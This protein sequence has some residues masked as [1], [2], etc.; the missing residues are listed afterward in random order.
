MNPNPTYYKRSKLSGDRTAFMFDSLDAYNRFIDETDRVAQGNTRQGLDMINPNW[1]RSEIRSE[2]SQ[3][4]GTTDA[5]LVIG[6]LDTYLFNPQLDSF[7]TSF[8]GQTVNVDVVDL[9]QQKAIKFTE[10]EI[11]IFSF[12]LA[13]LGLVP[14][15][16]YYSPLLDKVVSA[17]LIVGEKNQDGK[18]IFYHVYLPYIPMHKVLFDLSKNG[19]YSEILKRNIPKAELIDVVTE[20]EIYTAYPERNEVAKHIVEQRQQ[21]DDKGNKKFSSTFKKSFIY[22]PKV[23]KPLPRIDIICAASYAVGVNAE[24]QMIYSSM[25]AIAIAEKLSQSGVNFRI[26]GSYPLRTNGAGQPKSAYTFVVLKKEGEPFDK[27]KI[28][29]LLSDGRQFRYQQF[30]GFLTTFFDAGYDSNVNPSTI[31]TVIR[32]EDSVKQAYID[33]LKTQDSPEDRLAAENPRSKIVFNGALTESAARAQYDR[34]I[35]EISRI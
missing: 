2:G 7:L 26:V 21:L 34:V 10:L 31:G 5:N 25:A 11:G 27:N 13:S 4:F 8:R 19:Y 30:R 32:D 16:E 6:N 24:T 9:D 33:F 17:D 23:E 35:R 14:V 28:S 15:V 29:V 18:T 22:I 1:V 3:W 12:D 20:T